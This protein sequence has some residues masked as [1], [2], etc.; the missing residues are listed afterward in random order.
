MMTK[1]SLLF[2]ASLGFVAALGACGGGE[3]TGDDDGGVDAAPDLRC[4]VDQITTNGVS[5]VA[6]CDVW[7]AVDGPRDVARFHNPVNVAV[8]G[9]G[10][11]YVADFD[12]NRV[13]TVTP[14]G[15]VTTLVMQENFI[16]P[17]GLAIAGDGTLYV[18]TDDNPD[19]Q[20]SPTT[21]TIWRVN[22]DGEAT[23]IAANIG[24]PR[25]LAVLPDGDLVLSDYV[26]HTV[27][28]MDPS[29]GAMTLIAG[30]LDQAGSTNGTGAAARFNGPYGVALLPDGAIAV[31]EYEGNRIR[32]VALTGEVTTLAGTGAR[33]ETNGA[34]ATATFDK[35]QDL[36]ISADGTIYVADSE[37][38][39]IRRLSGDT[40]ST[41]V[42]AGIAGY[43][44]SEDLMA[45]ELF[46]LEG[47]DISPEDGML[48]IADGSRGED[49][50]PH[51][52]I[53]SANVD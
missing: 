29:S 43:L 28:R 7:A 36:A 46:G 33:G 41:V 12:N 20:H 34:A 44:D 51:H 2:S 39:V 35:P 1:P 30:A 40:V 8:R 31:A 52:R 24:R 53:R 13:R 47:I 48:Y 38:F 27:R 25:G 45:S 49:T 21:G 19:K 6:G 4:L 22:G 17:F 10:L 9:D 15:T 32:R 11:V 50:N 26:H 37:N 3:G 23:P 16:K 18:Q 14:D 5:T 42:G